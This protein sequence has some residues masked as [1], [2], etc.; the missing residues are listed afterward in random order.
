MACVY[1]KGAVPSVAG[2]D[3]TCEGVPGQ[4]WQVLAERARGGS[5][6]TAAGPDIVRG[7]SVEE[8]VNDAPPSYGC[9]FID[10]TCVL[11]NP[12]TAAIEPTSHLSWQACYMTKYRRTFGIY[13]RFVKTFVCL[14]IACLADNFCIVY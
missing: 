11:C 4:Q 3:V 5:I 12:L 14:H 7:G 1:S 2:R 13:N 6:P 9:I 8:C 10:C